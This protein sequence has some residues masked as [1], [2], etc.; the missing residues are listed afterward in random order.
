MEPSL[1]EFVRASLLRLNKVSQLDETL[2][3]LQKE[4]YSSVESLRLALKDTEAWATLKLPGR[5]KLELKEALQSLEAGNGAVGSDTGTVSVEENKE[6][7]RGE[8]KEKDCGSDDSAEKG[9]IATEPIECE[10]RARA[11]VPAGSTG[12]QPGSEDQQHPRAHVDDLFS[13]QIGIVEASGAPGVSAELMATKEKPRQRWLKCYSVQDSAVYYYHHD[14]GTTQWD[15]PVDADFEI[16]PS[17]LA[18]EEAAAEG[19]MTSYNYGYETNEG[20]EHAQIGGSVEELDQPQHQHRPEAEAGVGD[21]QY[22]DPASPGTYSYGSTP[23]TSQA[24]HMT[25]YSPSVGA[26]SPQYSSWGGEGQDGS[27]FY[28]AVD[29]AGEFGEGTGVYARPPAFAPEHEAP[30]APPLPSAV[31][32][33]AV[34][35][36]PII[37]VDMGVGVGVEAVPLQQPGQVS[38]FSPA[39]R[40]RR[41]RGT[42]TTKPKP[43]FT[44]TRSRLEQRRA[45]I[46]SPISDTGGDD[47][48][49]DDVV[50]HEASDGSGD[51][52]G[53]ERIGGRG[54]ND[55]DAGRHEREESSW[56]PG[57][58]LNSL[59]DDTFLIQSGGRECSSDSDDGM[60]NLAEMALVDTDDALDARAGTSAPLVDQANVERL[61]EMGFGEVAATDALV[62]TQN[63]LAHAAALLAGAAS[64]AP[65]PVV[66]S[67]ARMQRTAM[68]PMPPMDTL[69]GG[70]GKERDKGTRQ[71]LFQRVQGR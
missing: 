26:L 54:G 36:V 48:I 22:Y 32:A 11:S 71:N 17:I 6:K 34:A 56:V 30:S 58:Y 51:E 59:E 66:V 2:E 23:S 28:A 37:A 21:V 18:A 14:T 7:Q 24:S 49:D 25:M 52:H 4:W 61:K 5:L 47:D 50:Y 60:A 43:A 55:G 9:P 39:G 64:M 68:P 38:E 42:A 8:E 27:H 44:H 46:A 3:V 40:R 10:S 35:D 53:V 62:Q 19:T 31:T 57:A 33:V 20:H 69:D 70:G 29:E 67:E 45:W 41:A 65:D 13:A 12:D 15:V 1:I 16:D 63:R